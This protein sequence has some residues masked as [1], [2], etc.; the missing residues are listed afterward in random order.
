MGSSYQANCSCGFNQVVTVGGGRMNYMTHSK[1]PFYCKKCGLV[2]VNIS[3][4]RLCCPT[5]KSSKIKVYGKPPISHNTSQSQR[6]LAW[7]SYSAG[8]KDHLCPQCKKYT[9]FFELYMMFD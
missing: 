8:L 9:L 1:F 2:D 7:D 4:T 6:A 5:C 3:R